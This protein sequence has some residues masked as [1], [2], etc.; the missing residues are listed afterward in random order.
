MAGHQLVLQNDD[1]MQLIERLE[2][3]TLQLSEQAY[4]VAVDVEAV[5]ANAVGV[6]TISD[7]V[8]TLKN[9]NDVLDAQLEKLQELVAEESTKNAE[10]TKD[11]SAQK[12]KIE[13]LQKW[14][15]IHEERER[16]IKRQLEE[17]DR[18]IQ[19]KE[20]S[21]GAFQ[22]ENETLQNKLTNLQRQNE[23]HRKELKSNTEKL[24]ELAQSKEKILSLEKTVSDS[25]EEVELILTQLR[26][27]QD[28]VQSLEKERLEKNAKISELSKWCKVHEERELELKAQIDKD[29]KEIEQLEQRNRDLESENQALLELTKSSESKQNEDLRSTLFAAQETL[30]YELQVNA[31]LTEKNE[32]LSLQLEQAFEEL[33]HKDKHQNNRKA[34]DQQESRKLLEELLKTQEQLVTTHEALDEAKQYQQK[35]KGEQQKANLLREGLAQLHRQR[36]EQKIKSSLKKPLKKREK[37]KQ[38]FLRGI[39]SISSTPAWLSEQIQQVEHSSYFDKEWYVSHYSDLQSIDI[40]PA[41][42]FVRYGGFENR[43]PG[44]NFDTEFYVKKYPDVLVE[45]MNPLLHYILYGEAEGRLPRA[46]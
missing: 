43:N 8:E 46:S 20:K 24:Q 32:H 14:C 11:L 25:E 3:S 10:K 27:S 34:K 22:Q 5:L 28:S 18:L 29:N 30:E 45:G 7:E 4:H 31:E 36:L 17:K 21:N 9:E 16:E 39:P 23:E 6:K 44:P 2:A 1:M 37:Y 13:E 38:K 15:K 35:F 40:S 12:E 42:H 33:K 19:E 26:A 41:E